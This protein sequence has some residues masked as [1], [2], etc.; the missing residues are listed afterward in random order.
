MIIEVYDETTVTVSTPDGEKA[1]YDESSDFLTIPQV[2]EETV[3]TETE[4]TGT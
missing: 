3:P 2:S 4:T 1:I